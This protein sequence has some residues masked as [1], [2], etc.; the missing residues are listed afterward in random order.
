MSKDRL[1]QRLACRAIHVV[2][3]LGPKTVRVAGCTFRVTPDVFNP[4]FFITSQLMAGHL[5]LKPTDRVLDVGTG[6]AVQAIV[7]AKQDERVVAIDVNPE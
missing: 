3:R 2:Q 1:L 7:A 5:D 4:K 6:S